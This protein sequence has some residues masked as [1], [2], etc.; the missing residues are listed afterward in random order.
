MITYSNASIFKTLWWP[1]K[2]TGATRTITFPA[3][4]RSEDSRWYSSSRV[5]T[6]PIGCYQISVMYDGAY[7]H[8]LCSQI[9]V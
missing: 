4:H 6:L 9:E 1:I 7:Y 3:N 5:L 2:V 8:V